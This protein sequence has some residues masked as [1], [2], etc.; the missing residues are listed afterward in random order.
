MKTPEFPS[1]SLPVGAAA[2]MPFELEM[3]TNAHNYQKWVADTVQPYLGKRILE[4]GAG[5]GNMSQHL[6][7]RELLVLSE[8][9]EKLLSRLQQTAQ[10]LATTNNNASN[11][12]S[13]LVQKVDLAKS[14]AQQLAHHNFDTIISFNVFEHIEKDDEALKELLALLQKSQAPGPKHLVTFV[15]AHQWTFSALDRAFGHYRRYS[16]R[17]FETLVEKTGFQGKLAM[18]YFNAAGLPGWLAIK[19]LQKKTIGPIAM[20]GFETICPF[21]RDIDDFLHEK[22]Q[23]PLGQS[24]L[25]VMTLEEKNE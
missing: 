14:L 2:D 7:V 23:L 4:V 22:L 19:F 10:K 6:P 8:A 15:P 9:E 17:S 16:K 3:L 13:V 1:P 21:V 20:K 18:R 12:S 11:K 24:L 25:A 5:I